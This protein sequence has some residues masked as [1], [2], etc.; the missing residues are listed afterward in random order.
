MALWTS[1]ELVSGWL[2]EMLGNLVEAVLTVGVV[3][4][5]PA[6]VVTVIAL[7]LILMRS[8]HRR[9]GVSGDSTVHQ[10]PALV[11][12]IVSV[13]AGAAGAFVSLEGYFIGIGLAAALGWLLF[14]QA[15]RHRWFALGSYL[16]G[17]GLCG[18]GFLSPALTNHDPA[19]SYDAST[20]PTFWFA[21]VLA[22]CGV[23]AVVAATTAQARGRPA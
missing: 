11:Y 12:V 2:R 14:R 13:L 9:L 3:M 5:G 10:P 23:I 21:V 20:I 16:L 7:V 22:L 18:A 8:H 4:V 17:M 1:P 6:A 19:V 15:R